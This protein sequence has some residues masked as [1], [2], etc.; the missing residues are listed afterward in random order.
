MNNV[1]AVN[2]CKRARVMIVHGLCAV[3]VCVWVCIRR[4]SYAHRHYGEQQFNGNNEQPKNSY[5][6]K[7]THKT[8]WPVF[9][10]F[11]VLTR[12]LCLFVFGTQHISFVDLSHLLSRTH[13]ARSLVRSYAS[14]LCMDLK[15]GRHRRHSRR[16]VHAHASHIWPLHQ[17]VKWIFC[18]VFVFRW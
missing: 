10:S 11:L 12:L 7:L 8:F 6:Q 9:F 13:A 1:W 4:A 16:H 2:L 15:S 17:I 18:G 5:I 14:E 3:C